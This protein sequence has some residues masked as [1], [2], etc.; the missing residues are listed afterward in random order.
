MGQVR[1]VGGD[2]YEGL[3]SHGGHVSSI[4]GGMTTTDGWPTIL[5]CRSAESN[6]LGLILANSM[7]VNDPSEPSCHD[8]RAAVQVATATVE[9]QGKSLLCST[10]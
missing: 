4:I 1:T 2:R 3:L 9:F 7:R 8:L 10:G 6:R 5:S